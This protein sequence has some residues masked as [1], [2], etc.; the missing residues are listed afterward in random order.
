MVTLLRVHQSGM[1][2]RS[3]PRVVGAA[4]Y[5]ERPTPE[6]CGLRPRRLGALVGGS[7]CRAG[8]CTSRLGDDCGARQVLASAR[9]TFQKRSCCGPQATRVI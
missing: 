8:C 2:I 5:Q 7:T 6:R 4:L 3:D 9:W 1:C